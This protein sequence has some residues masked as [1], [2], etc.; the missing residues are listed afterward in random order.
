MIDD[1]DVKAFMDLSLVDEL[2]DVDRVRQ[3]L[4]EVSPADRPA[5]Y[6]L[7]GPV[8][9]QQ[10]RRVETDAQASEEIRRRS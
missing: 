7:A 6:A 9:A 8:Q 5:A 2:P 3:D 1:R 4:V 10:A